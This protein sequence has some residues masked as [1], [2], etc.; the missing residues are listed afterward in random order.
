MT[1]NTLSCNNVKFDF[2]LAGMQLVLMNGSSSR[3]KY[4][5]AQ[6]IMNNSCRRE[7]EEVTKLLFLIVT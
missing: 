5:S 7:E 1:W 2:R 4:S 6:L 3:G